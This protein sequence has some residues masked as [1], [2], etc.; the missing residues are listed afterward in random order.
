MV[1]SRAAVVSTYQR[2]C[3][4]VQTSNHRPAETVTHCSQ[5][6]QGHSVTNHKQ[7]ISSDQR[8]VS[9]HPA[10]LTTWLTPPC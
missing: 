10:V 2:L 6:L 1:C 7:L 4:D 9:Q 3:T 5:R 8:N